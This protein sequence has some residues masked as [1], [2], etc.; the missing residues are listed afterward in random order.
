MQLLFTYFGPLQMLFDNEAVPM[1][2]WPVLFAGGLV[3][4]SVIEVEKLIIRSSTSLRAFVTG[5]EAGVRAK[6]D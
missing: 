3:F 4:F 2:V 5:V 6:A 1:R